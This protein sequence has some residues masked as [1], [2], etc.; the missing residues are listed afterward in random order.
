MKFNQ[1]LATIYGYLCTDGY[2]ITNPPS[3]K[4]KYYCIGLRNKNEIILQ[5]FQKN[6]E[7][8]FGIKPIKE[9]DRCKLQNKNLFLQ[10][11]KNFSFYSVFYSDKWGMSK[12]SLEELKC[13]LRAYFDCDA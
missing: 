6:F 4:H 2:V 10:L 1:N 3:Q 7:K 5:D 8:A 9:K 11:T 13:R 12:L